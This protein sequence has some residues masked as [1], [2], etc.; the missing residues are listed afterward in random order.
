[1]D[2]FGFSD[3]DETF[4]DY[5][6]TSSDFSLCLLFLRLISMKR[7][8]NERQEARSSNIR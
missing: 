1:M 7:T 3:D 4:V 6:E 8:T 5:K 2:G